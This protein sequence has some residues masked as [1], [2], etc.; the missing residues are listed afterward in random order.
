MH[1]DQG[2]STRVKFYLYLLVFLLTFA[3]SAFCQEGVEQSAGARARKEFT[4]SLGMKLVE[5][6]GSPVAIS[7]WETRVSDWDTYLKHEGMTWTHRPS[8]PQTSEDPAVNITLPEAMAFCVW[9]TEHERGS[10]QIQ[11]SQTYRLPT[12]LEWD[13]ATGITADGNQSNALYPWGDA[14]PPMRQ[15]GNYCTRRIAG[16]RDDGFEFTAPVGQF[17]PSRSGCYDLGGNAWEWTSDAD[18]DGA[19]ISGLR[20]GSWMYWR[21]DCLEAQYIYGAPSNTRSPGIGFRC[22]LEDAAE[23][24]RLARARQDS[25]ARLME[26]PEIDQKEIE[27]M[28]RKLME[29]RKPKE[30]EETTPAS[31]KEA[32]T[33]K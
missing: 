18:P 15:S 26:K 19:V 32:P 21:R 8:F 20:G 27:E 23:V 33:T 30:G 11:S 1:D 24:A 29:R 6:P 5:L 22:V 28:K 25:A 3:S 31:P 16:G 14:W 13:A 2:T 12:K 10:G 9:L 4:N 7:I 17:F